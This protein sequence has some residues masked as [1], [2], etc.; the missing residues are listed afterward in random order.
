MLARY[1]QQFSR[2]G[3]SLTSGGVFHF[4]AVSADHKV[5]A[6]ISTSGF[7]TAS[8]KPGAGKMNNMRSDIYFLFLASAE[9]K[10]VL[11]TEQDMYARW[12]KEIE[13]GRVPRS[14]EFA[15]VEIPA[16]LDVK[17]RASRQRAS[18]EVTPE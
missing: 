6:A 18:R 2:E 14:I 4:D 13:N 9:R 1:G 15:R 17:L 3:I 12:V 5:V 10:L 11:L 16:H 8:G 7:K